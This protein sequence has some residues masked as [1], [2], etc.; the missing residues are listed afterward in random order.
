MTLDFVRRTYEILKLGPY[1]LVLSTRPAE[2]YI[3]ALEDWDQAEAA[4]KNALDHSGQSWTLNEGDGAFYGPKIDIVLRDS[5]GKEHQTATVQLDF[6]LP[7]RFELE[8]QAPAPELEQKGETTSDP[9]LLA[10]SG[11]VRPVLIH[12]AVLGSV[13]RLLALLVEHYD[14]KWPFWLNPRQGIVLTLNDSAPVVSFARRVRD[15]LV[16]TPDP[17]DPH[18]TPSQLAI[19]VDES[20]RTLSLKVREAKSK[21]YG[22]VIVVGPKD[23]AK[24]SV[25]VDTAGI[26]G[27]VPDGGSTKPKPVEM[28][29]EELLEFLKGP[30]ADGYDMSR[31][32]SRIRYERRRWR[33]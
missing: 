8:Y 28:T 15:I 24:G 29:P 7:K 16:G 20:P 14:G 31:G 2:H 23:V 9:A 13:E 12:R 19:D 4:L 22:A 17:N 26:P 6:Q 32:G 27:T 1:R 5:D 18:F 11:A 3:G 21:G 10:E 30:C 33:V 25:T